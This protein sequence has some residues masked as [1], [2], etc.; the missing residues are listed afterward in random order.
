M[1]KPRLYLLLLI[2][3]LSACDWGRTP[4][5]IRFAKNCN[6]KLPSSIHVIKDVYEDMGSDYAIY[7]IVKFSKPDLKG[8]LYRIKQSSNYYTTPPSNENDSSSRLL[9]K[10]YKEGAWYK[11]RHYYRFLKE[12]RGTSFNAFVDTVNSTVEFQE[13]GR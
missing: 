9:I 11:S 6:V 1:I 7:Y 5:N 8:L 12:N 2:L 13:F 4:S 3:L 10:Q